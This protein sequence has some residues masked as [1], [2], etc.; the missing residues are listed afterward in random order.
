MLTTSDERNSTHLCDAAPTP[1]PNNYR[2]KFESTDRNRDGRDYVEHQRTPPSVSSASRRF[3][4]ISAETR[5][6]A[7][8]PT[9]RSWRRSSTSSPSRTR[10]SGTPAS[11]AT[12]RCGSSRTTCTVDRPAARRSCP[13][14]QRRRGEAPQPHRRLLVRLA[15]WPLRRAGAYAKSQALARS[16]AA[17]DRPG[18]IPAGTAPDARLGSPGVVR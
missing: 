14:R 12:P 15:R 16:D 18:F 6:G 1:P 3:S 9:A 4:K 11:A 10:L 13:F 8:R 17:P 7:T 5:R 2:G